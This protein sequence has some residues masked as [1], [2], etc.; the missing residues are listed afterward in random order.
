[1][2]PR[3]H[4]QNAL[5]ANGRDRR[6]LITATLLFVACT[7]RNAAGP[8]PLPAD[9]PAP[10]S[11]PAAPFRHPGIL[12]N[13]AQLEFVRDQI[14]AGHQP[15][16]EAYAKAM[17][18]K[19]G[20]LA[21]TPKPRATVDCGAYSR[22]NN[23]CSDERDDAVAAYTHALAWFMTGDV[24]HADKAV[25]IMNAWAAVVRG[26]SNHNA[27]LQTGWAGAIWP[28]A[29]EIIR[30]TSN[31]W[32]AADTAAFERMLRVVYLDPI[33]DGSDTTNGNWELVMV[34]AAT[35]IAIF[36]DDRPAF[37]HALALWRRRLP[38][39]FYLSSDGPA[40][41]PP[42]GR[43]KAPADLIAFWHGQTV[44]VDG[45]SQETCRDFGHTSY[46]LASALAT[47]ELAYQQGVD[48]Y[49]Q[50]APRLHAAM[51]F[52]AT[53]LLGQPV[54]PWLCGGHID[55]RVLPTWEIGY[56][57]FHGRL[58][59]ELPRSRQ[60]IESKIRARGGV[61]HHIVWETLTHAQ[62]GG[63]GLP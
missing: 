49:Q 56:N 48:L 52:H 3:A 63:A 34:E 61:D 44:F 41:L 27:P 43:P 58:G 31:A 62:V 35:A 23:G 22:P 13:R 54:P 16:S 60:L 33:A 18:S 6:W 17:A 21:W 7:H 20:S 19:Y 42:P 46:G 14:K 45:L 37:D 29:A 15:W 47:A 55:A 53:F 59:L 50:E 26:H 57:H 51:E 40:P 28:L 30:H 39:Y 25:A 12:T 5:T 24:A 10:P 11:A 36:L 4:T 8:A 9:R 2:H 1:L 38:A 32:S